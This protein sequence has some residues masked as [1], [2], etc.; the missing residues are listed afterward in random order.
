[1]SEN[2][3]CPIIDSLLYR[4]CITSAECVV[5]RVGVAAGVQLNCPHSKAIT[6]YGSTRDCYGFC[7]LPIHL[8]IHFLLSVSS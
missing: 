6:E 3:W 1:M 2:T 7:I 4:A 5:D 8:E